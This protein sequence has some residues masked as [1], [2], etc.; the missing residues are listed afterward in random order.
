MERHEEIRGKR[1]EEKHLRGEPHPMW[2]D[3]KLESGETSGDEREEK[4]RR[5]TGERRRDWA[6]EGRERNAYMNSERK[7]K[8]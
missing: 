1:R 8:L 2:V 5:K 3:R 7:R 6:W 4:R